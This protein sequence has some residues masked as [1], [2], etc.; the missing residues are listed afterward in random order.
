MA[1][2]L[3]GKPVLDYSSR[4]VMAPYSGMWQI[5]LDTDHDVSGGD[6]TF[7]VTPHAP[8]DRIYTIEGIYVRSLSTHA[9]SD[10]RIYITTW[11]PPGGTQT[12]VSLAD[13]AAAPLFHLWEP[14][15]PYHWRST[16]STSIMLRVR[17][18]NLDGENTRMIA[19][20]RFYEG[21]SAIPYLGDS[22]ARPRIDVF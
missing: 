10:V 8:I 18:D 22:P 16:K 21:E 4:R 15:H 6:V 11:M 13:F 7:N 19:W 5:E 12:Q 20:G 14:E 3:E 1:I 2:T 17:E 9:S